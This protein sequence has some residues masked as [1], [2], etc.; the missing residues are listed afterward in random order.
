MRKGSSK[1]D[2]LKR[3][4]VNFSFYAEQKTALR[5]LAEHYGTTESFVVAALIEKEFFRIKK[6]EERNAKKTRP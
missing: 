1:P 3:R 2:N 4:Q 5:K 6:I